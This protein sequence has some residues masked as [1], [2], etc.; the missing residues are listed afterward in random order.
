MRPSTPLALV[1]QAVK[2][3]TCIHSPFSPEEI[4]GCRP[5]GLSGRGRLKGGSAGRRIAIA[6]EEPIRVEPGICKA[7]PEADGSP[8]TGGVEGLLGVVGGQ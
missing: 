5:L 6:E 8:S 1:V 3:L 4:G 2:A 7:Q